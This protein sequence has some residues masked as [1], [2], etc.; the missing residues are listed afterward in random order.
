MESTRYGDIFEYITAQE[1]AF[2]LPIRLNDNWEWGMAEHIRL[3][4]L[5]KNSQFSSGKDDNK[6]FKN[7]VRPILNLQYRSEGFDVKDIEIFIDDAQKYFKSFLIRKF[8]EKWARQNAIDTFI[9][10]LVESYVDFGGALIKNVKGI[11]PEVVPLQNLVFCDQTDILSGPLGIKHFMSP[12]QLLEMESA[13]WGETSNGAT[14]SLKE[15]IALSRSERKDAQGDKENTKTPGKYIEVYEVH[16]QFPKAFIEGQDYETYSNQLHIVCFYQK[17]GKK[18][19]ITLW[20][21]KETK[22][23]FKFIKRDPV[24]G[25]ALGFGGA[26]ELFEAQVWTNYSEIQKKNML[27]A[28]SKVIF[29]SND[30]TIRQKHPTGL[31]DID[32]MEIIDEA[33]E[34]NTRQLDTTPRNFQF[35]DKMVNEWEAHAQ[36]MGAA[37]DSIMGE[38]P[39]SGT[40]FKLQELVTAEAHSLHAYRQG[41]LATFLEEI[42]REWVLP[43]LVREVG[44]GQQFLSELSLDELTYVADS[45]VQCAENDWIKKK[46]LEGE[47]IDEEEREQLKVL[48]K[49]VFMKAGTKRFMEI[50]EGEMKDADLDLY[51]NVA[52][53]QKDI[54]QKV[55]KLV[56]VFRQVVAAPQVLDDPRMAKLFNEIL[57]GSGLSPINFYQKPAAQPQPGEATLEAPKPKEVTPKAV[58]AY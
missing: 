46:M 9:D 39:P 43:H 3:T 34:G 2:R 47:L 32:S 28:A 4:V 44:K 35:F 7:I 29:L 12:D 37:N 27:D 40:P 45:V 57:E 33:A 52:G 51:V 23:P 18:N 5:Y 26:E 20:K 8:H 56:N 11:K 58:A 14:A 10:A 21:G 19:G 54:T 1:T 50:Y 49:D 41:K 42:Y 6:P 15:A 48:S 53:K 25:R 55:D 24:H 31:K 17:Q 30:P 13:G 16:G 36:M 38:T 22:S